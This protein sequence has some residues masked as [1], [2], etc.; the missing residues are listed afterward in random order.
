MRCYVQRCT[1]RGG[2]E[3]AGLQRAGEHPGLEEGSGAAEE[4]K[5]SCGCCLGGRTALQ[6]KGVLF[7][8]PLQC[9]SPCGA[10]MGPAGCTQML[11][12]CTQG[13]CFLC[14]ASACSQ[15]YKALSIRSQHEA[16]S[17]PL[18]C[19]PTSAFCFP[20]SGAVGSTAAQGCCAHLGWQCDLVAVSLQTPPW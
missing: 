13:L 12:L 6:P 1:W 17:E 7:P 16:A 2:R 20:G 18:P 11:Q 4:P 15:P 5:N 14:T 3:G 9:P 10:S 19:S 8:V